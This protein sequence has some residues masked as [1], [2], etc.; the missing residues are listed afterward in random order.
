MKAMVAVTKLELLRNTMWKLSCF[1]CCAAAM[2]STSCMLANREIDDLAFVSADVVKIYEYAGNKDVGVAPETPV[3]ASEAPRSVMVLKIQFSSK[4]DLVE[5][6][7]RT[8]FNLSS[9]LHACKSNG[10]DKVIFRGGYV[11]WSGFPI[12]PGIERD[13]HHAGK[14]PK[15]IRGQ[16]N[17]YNVYISIQSKEVKGGPFASPAYDLSKNPQNLCLQLVGGNMAGGIFPWETFV[18]NTIV[19]PQEQLSTAL[20]KHP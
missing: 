19:I 4:I 9:N 20:Q 18:S 3:P 2:A 7:E 14:V 6:T 8:G 15:R 17:T 10:N 1:A 13:P 11:Y 16:A 5:F 12:E